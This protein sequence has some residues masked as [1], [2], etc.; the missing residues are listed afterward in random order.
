MKVAWFL[1]DLAGGGAER[2]PLILAPYFRETSLHLVL[3]KNHVQHALPVPPPRLTALL[4]AEARLGRSAWRLLRAAIE[5]SRDADLLVG[6]MEWDS[7]LAAVAAGLWLRRPVVAIVHTDLHRLYATLSIPAWRWRIFAWALRRCRAVLAVSRD[8]GEAAVRFG[9]PRN[10]C[11]VIPNP[12]PIVNVVTR[13]HASPEASTPKRLLTIGR[14]VPMKAIDVLVATAALL[15]DLDFQ[16]DVLGDGPER[17]N[18]EAQAQRLG[19]GRRLTFHGFVLDPSPFFES[20]DLFV[21]SSRFEGMPLAM[22]EAMRYGL[23]LVAT[24]CSHGVED[25]VGEGEKAAGLLVPVEDP[26][27]LA[28][29]ICGALES[30]QEFPRWAENARA[31]VAELGPPSIAA[32]YEE[33]FKGLIDATD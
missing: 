14:L 23:P 1:T 12:A 4:P 17:A 32:R 20:A 8:G 21:L 28:A 15:G 19:L 24:R 16:W 25:L 29:A 30:P 26:A 18:V 9:V 3:L 7:T 13:E 2:L 22:T 10:R 11:H 5:A 33:L 6:G 31:R 27:A